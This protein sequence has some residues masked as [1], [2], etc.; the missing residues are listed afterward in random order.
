MLFFSTCKPSNSGPSGPVSKSDMLLN[1]GDI[2]NSSRIRCLSRV[3]LFCLPINDTGRWHL[4]LDVRHRLDSTLP[5]S[6]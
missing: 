1:S 5:L 6:Y 3:G 4:L 2:V